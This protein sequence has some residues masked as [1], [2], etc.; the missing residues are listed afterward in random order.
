M[1]L[2]YIVAPTTSLGYSFNLSPRLPSLSS[3]NDAII[4]SDKWE[5]SVGNSGLHPFNHI[6]NTISAAYYKSNLYAML[7]C[8]YASNKGAIMPTITRTVLN[9]GSVVF[10]NGVFNQINMSQWVVS[11]YLRYALPNNKF[12]ITLNSSYNWFNAKAT[13][14]TNSKGFVNGN[15]SIESYVGKFHFSANINTRY[16][17]LFAETTWFNEYSNSITAT[18]NYRSIQIGLMWEQPFQSK[19]RN[20]RVETKNNVIYKSQTQNNRDVANNVILTIVWNWNKG[21]KS[22]ARAAEI[23]NQDS[24]SGIMK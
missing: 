7:N 15:L 24:D 17:S 20:S 16:N 12:I 10:D 5:R 22:K 11:A 18:Y 6:E 4:Q 19:G 8:T 23:N 9:D 14:Y 21:L 3:L 13:E 1:N 2:Y